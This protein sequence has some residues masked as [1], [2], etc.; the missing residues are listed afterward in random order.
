MIGVFGGTFDPFHLGHLHMARRARD[1]LGAKIQ[2][3]LAARP[4]HREG[5]GGSV[6]ARW[7]ML[8]VGLEDEVDLT[9][10][11][12][13]I[14]RGGPSY[15]VDTLLALREA[16]GAVEPIVWVIGRDAYDFVPNWHRFGE[17]AQLCHLL[18]FD[19]GDVDDRVPLRGFSV[20]DDPCALGD[21]PAGR[22]LFAGETPPPV[23]ST[24]VRATLVRGADASALLP[25]KVWS[26]IETHG[27]YRSE[28][29]EGAT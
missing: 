29:R 6:R 27:L 23:S 28:Y 20:V 17:V 4:W 19:R 8:C 14:D 10:S 21:R 24:E 15:S 16:R 25:P 22:I 2:V 7:E 13:E 1:L 26:Y 11:A 9:P 18:V 12:I 5:L 3:V